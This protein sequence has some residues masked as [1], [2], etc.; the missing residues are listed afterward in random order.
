MSHLCQKG[1]PELYLRDRDAQ[2]GRQTTPADIINSSAYILQAYFGAERTALNDQSCALPIFDFGEFEALSPR[3]LSNHE[4][5]NR[6]V[7]A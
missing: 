7:L 4:L 3:E 6:K 2:S 1:S 5:H